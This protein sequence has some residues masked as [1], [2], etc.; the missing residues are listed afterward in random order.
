MKLAC[1]DRRP[2]SMCVCAYVHAM[3]CISHLRDPRPLSFPIAILGILSCAAEVAKDVAVR[4]ACGV[5]HPDSGEGPASQL[6]TL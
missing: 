4:V 6:R 5:F 3:S 2:L 1:L